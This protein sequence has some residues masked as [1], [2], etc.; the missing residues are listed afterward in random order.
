M[1][2]D[3]SKIIEEFGNVAEF[4]RSTPYTPSMYFA[5]KNKKS[6]YFSAK[7]STF[8]LYKFLQANNYILDADN[9][10]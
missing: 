6:N 8:K 10:K 3:E 9:D 2:I 7:S 5:L 1:K 4:L